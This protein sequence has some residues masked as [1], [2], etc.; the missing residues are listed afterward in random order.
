MLIR[1]IFKFVQNPAKFRYLKP[2]PE[3]PEVLRRGEF[4]HNFLQLYDGKIRLHYVEAGD[5]KKPL[6][7]FVHGFPEF[8]Y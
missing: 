2:R 1:T 5:P 4:R 7:L 8:W 6:L 3:P